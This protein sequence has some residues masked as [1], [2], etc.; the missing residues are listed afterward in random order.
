MSDDTISPANG[1]KLAPAAKRALEEA[2]QRRK[3]NK[4]LDPRPT[5][6]GGPK[7]IEPTRFGDWERGGI[8]YDF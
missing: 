8:A 5:E 6:K 4:Q 1:K 2:A 7:G 3:A